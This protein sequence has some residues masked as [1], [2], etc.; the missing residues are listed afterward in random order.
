MRDKKGLA[1]IFSLVFAVLFSIVPCYG[2]GKKEQQNIAQQSGLVIIGVSPR[3]SSRDDSI[4]TAVEDAAR[5]LSFFYYVSGYYISMEHIGSDF[6]DVH[7]DAAYK[8]HYDSE[9]DKYIEQLEYNPDIDVFEYNN[10]VFVITKVKNV[11]FMPRFKGH[12]FLRTRPSW[13][14]SPPNEIDGFVTG[15]GFSGN[16]S[17]HKDAVVRS[18]ENAVI[19]L[20]KRNEV[21]VQGQLSVIQDNY[22]GFGTEV[23]TSVETRT[24][25]TLSNFYIIETWTDPSNLSVWTL[26]VAKKETR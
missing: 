11:V 13:I 16:L 18:Y 15:V 6:F 26:A 10:A 14:D 9:L 12:S 3:L 5:K 8:L 24:A 20:I 17:S 22:S 19:S 23:N 21:M 1:L 7:F 4:K 25:G 2:G